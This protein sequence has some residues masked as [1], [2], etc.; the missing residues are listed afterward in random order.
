MDRCHRWHHFASGTF[1]KSYHI[2]KSYEIVKINQRNSMEITLDL[3]P[4]TLQISNKI[5]SNEL[6]RD[7]PKIDLGFV[8]K[9]S[10]DDGVA[11]ACRVFHSVF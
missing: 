11:V 9:T 3:L 1:L 2:G 7:F 6:F 8:V 5:C 10:S 4:Q